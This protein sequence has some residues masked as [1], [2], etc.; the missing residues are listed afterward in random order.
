MLREYIRDIDSTEYAWVTLLSAVGVIIFHYFWPF[1]T[2][3]FL[4]PFVLSAIASIAFIIVHSFWPLVWKLFAT[5]RKWLMRS[6]KNANSALAERNR[7]RNR[8]SSMDNDEKEFISF[9]FSEITVPGAIGAEM[10]MGPKLYWAGCRLASDGVVLL[11][12]TSTALEFVITK[13]GINALISN[14]FPRKPRRKKLILDPKLVIVS[15]ASG[16]G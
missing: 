16:G 7:L 6:W 14:G 11:S 12:E 3:W 5:T 1:D 10:I 13:K 9:F 2:S 8:I 4:W 15:L